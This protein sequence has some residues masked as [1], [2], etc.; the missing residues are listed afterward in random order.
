[1]S[2][3]SKA[4]AVLGVVAGLGVAAMPLSTYAATSVT[5]S[6]ATI[7]KAEVKRS[8]AIAVEDTE[9]AALVNDTLD[10]GELMVNGAANTKDMNV[11]VYSNSDTQKFNLSIAPAGKTA[12]GTAIVDMQNTDQTNHPSAVIPAAATFGNGTAGWGFKVGDATDWTKLEATGNTL[13]SEAVTSEAIVPKTIG[14]VEYRNNKVTKVTF[15]AAAD[16]NTAEGTYTVDVV[17]T[18][19]EV[20]GA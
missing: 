11:L 17:F 19:T 2:K 3:M 14:G 13:V 12:D 9:G 8:L 10:L 7:I 20:A 4:V 1:M 5:S 18:A 6:P 15:G 16:T